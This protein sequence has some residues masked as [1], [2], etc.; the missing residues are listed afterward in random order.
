M[1]F[2]ISRFEEKFIL[3]IPEQNNNLKYIHKEPLNERNKMTCII[4]ARCHD[5]VLLA[6]DTRVMRGF[7]IS[8]QNKIISPHKIPYVYASSGTV[9]LMDVFIQ[10]VGELISDMNA[11]KVEIKNAN[12]FKEKLE[13]IVS[14]IY[15]RY[16]SREPNAILDVFVSYSP[17]NNIPAVLYHIYPKGFSEN[18]TEFDIIGSGK[19]YVLPFIQSAYHAEITVDEMTDVC[20]YVLGLMDELQIDITVGDLPQIVVIKDIAEKKIVQ[21][22]DKTVLKKI[23]QYTERNNNESLSDA[24][25]YFLITSNDS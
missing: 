6:G 7:K 1:N 13:D 25:S 18:V 23:N 10:K 5:G 22:D 9:A 3:Y 8:R 4:S 2:N 14:E 12:E 17:I 11:K 21:L 24:L 20:C 15:N 16:T 19:P